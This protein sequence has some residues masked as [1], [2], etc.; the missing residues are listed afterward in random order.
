MKK[1]I[2]TI[3]AVSLGIMFVAAGSASAQQS[4]S[5]T[6]K[7]AQTTTAQMKIAPTRGTTTSARDNTAHAWTAGCYAEFGPNASNPDAACWRSASAIDAL[8]GTTEIHAAGGFN[9]SNG[10]SLSGD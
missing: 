6:V 2:L 3:A 5:T 9:I 4:R 7:P 8:H 10:V 1:I